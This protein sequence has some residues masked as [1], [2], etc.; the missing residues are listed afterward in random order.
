MRAELALTDPLDLAQRSSA[1]NNLPGLDTF[2][3]GVAD[4]ALEA[5]AAGLDLGQEV[6]AVKHLRSKVL[7]FAAGRA[8]PIVAEELADV[9][10]TIAKAMITAADSMLAPV[11]RTAWA[12]TSVF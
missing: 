5:F 11:A 2:G 6:L 1:L 4:A 10:E 7:E 12:T 3:P 9:F 8:A